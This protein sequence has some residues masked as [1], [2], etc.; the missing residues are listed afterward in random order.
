MIRENVS[1]LRLPV[2]WH[3]RY[4]DWCMV[5]ELSEQA[6]GSICKGPMGGIGYPE[7]SITNDQ[8]YV[9]SH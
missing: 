3:I 4:V 6:V 7:W 9:T 5:A 2:L 1:L 8:G